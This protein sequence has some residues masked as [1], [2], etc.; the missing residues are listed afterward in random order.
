MIRWKTHEYEVQIAMEM[1]LIYLAQAVGLINRWLTMQEAQKERED[2]LVLRL[3]E[4]L[5]PYVNGEKDK[6]KD[7]ANDE[8][9][10][11]SGG[12]ICPISFS[13]R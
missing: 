3:I 8:A 2:K 12:G 6:F 4:R 1:P 7:W 9:E 5:Q 10:R 11:L 13:F